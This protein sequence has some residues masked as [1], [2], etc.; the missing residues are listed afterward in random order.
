[1]ADTFLRLGDGLGID[2][3]EDLLARV[4]PTTVWGRRQRTGLT[5]DLRRARRDATETALAGY[6]DLPEPEAAQRF[7]AAG[8]PPWTGPA[9]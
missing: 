1:V 7:L 9:P 8:R 2:R 5:A 3:L 6:P 4:T